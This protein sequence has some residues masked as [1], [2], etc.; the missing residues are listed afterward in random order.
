MGIYLYE[1]SLRTW[2][3]LALLAEMWQAEDETKNG[4]K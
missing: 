4:S 1:I 3:A 2:T